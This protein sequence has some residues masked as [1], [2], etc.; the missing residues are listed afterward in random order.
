MFDYSAQAKIVL[1]QGDSNALDLNVQAEKAVDL[2][3]TVITTVSGILTEYGFKVLG[4][5]LILVIGRIVAKVLSSWISKAMTKAKVDALLVAFTE[6]LSFVGMMVFVVVAALDTLG[7]PVVSFVGII[8]AAG[9]AIGLALQ[10]SLSNFAAGVL[11]IIFKPIRVGDFVE[12]GGTKGAVQEI[13]MFNTILNSPDNIRVIVPNSQVTGGCIRNYSTNKTRR[14][15]LVIGVGY[16]DDLSKA[17]E[18]IQGVLSQDERVLQDPA[19]TIAVSELADSSVNFVVRPWVK[20]SDYWDVY[21][22]LTENIKN[23]LDAN[24]ISIPFPQRD[25]HVKTPIAMASK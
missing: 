25:I 16:E 12:I 24:H 14:V 6:D 18:V 4:A 23:A 5:I 20:T 11:M 8:A 7:I 15:D 22:E 9:L 2:A 13:Q 17:R 1:A 3:Q 10:G 21:F 19:P